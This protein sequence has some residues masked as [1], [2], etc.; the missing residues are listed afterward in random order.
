MFLGTIRR[1]LEKIAN[2][3]A[4]TKALERINEANE[5][6]I[7]VG[8][9]EKKLLEGQLDGERYVSRLKDAKI[10]S[11]EIELKNALAIIEAA[12]AAEAGKWK[13]R[14]E[15]GDLARKQWQQRRR[16]F[17]RR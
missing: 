4:M 16:R 10:S 5:R 2:L 3:E 9:R 14:P 17:R 7:A 8:E 13:R 1:L 6:R 15:Q 11:L 12:K